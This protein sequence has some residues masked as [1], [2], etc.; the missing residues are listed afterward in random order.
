M[1]GLAGAGKSAVA[2]VL[3]LCRWDGTGKCALYVLPYVALCEQKVHSLSKLLQPLGRS[4]PVLESRQSIALYTTGFLL[5]CHLCFLSRNHST[6]DLAL[7]IH[8]SGHGRMSLCP[9]PGRKRGWHVGAEV[10]GIC[11]CMTKSRS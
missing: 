11:W 2:E 3:T 1:L 7:V 9:T 8:M 5:L 4:A 6:D 10:H